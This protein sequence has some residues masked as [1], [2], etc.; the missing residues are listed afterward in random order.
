[1]ALKRRGTERRLTVCVSLPGIGT[2]A[3]AS[4]FGYLTRS[5]APEDRSTVF[6]AVMACRQAGLLIGQWHFQH[7]HASCH[8]VTLCCASVYTIHLSIPLSKTGPACNIFLRLCNFQLGPF[9]VNKFTAPGVCDHTG[10]YIYVAF[11]C[12]RVE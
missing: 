9:V 8:N 4:I 5:T 12:A 2:G 1:M 10:S 7:L 11:F 6:A 3:G